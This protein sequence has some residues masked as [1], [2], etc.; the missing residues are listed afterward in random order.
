M[1]KVIFNKLFFEGALHNTN[2]LLQRPIRGNLTATATNEFG[3]TKH[4]YSMRPGKNGST[5]WGMHFTVIIDVEMHIHDIEKHGSTKAG[6]LL[7]EMVHAFLTHYACQGKQYADEKDHC[8][9]CSC[10]INVC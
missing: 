8:H 6:I 1:L 7:H 5:V 10:E 4:T 2:V 3:V 9:G